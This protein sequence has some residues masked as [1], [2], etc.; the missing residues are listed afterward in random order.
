MHDQNS[1][2][3][4]GV[5]ADCFRDRKVVLFL[6][7][8]ASCVGAPTETALPTGG[9]F[10]S[11]LA[12]KS[13]YPGKS[14]DPLTKI[15]QFLEEVAADRK[16]LLRY[17]NSIFCKSIDEGYVT[18]LSIFL[19]NLPSIK[20]PKLIVTTNYDVI[21]ERT[22]EKRKI[23]YLSLSHIMRGTKLFG[24]FLCY[25]SL[26]AN[27]D[28]LTKTQLEERLLELE[29]KND[30]TVLIYK[31]HGTARNTDIPLDSIVLTETDYIDFLAEDM[32]KRIPTGILD[33]L[34]GNS[35]LFLGYKL[36]DWNFRVLLQR[37]L[38][39]QRQEDIELRHWACL[40][41]PDPVEKTFWVK[42]GV[43]LY[44][45]SLDHFLSNLANKLL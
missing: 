14:S 13:A 40:L 44:D 12:S 35:I 45:Q 10:A 7:A 16:F 29:E 33:V 26:D 41:D 25:N 5:I 36:E 32:L 18:S 23:P 24:R 11:D 42:R 4:Y 27:I 6:G 3:P 2:V 19:S 43:T 15:S 38:K 21:I 37:I 17:V 22:L 28:I 9:K 39:L 8:A 1:T 30:G 34:R 31:M 20:I